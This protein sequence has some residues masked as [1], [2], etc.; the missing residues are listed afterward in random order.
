MK[1]RGFIVVWLTL[2]LAFGCVENPSGI[3][4]TETGNGSSG[5]VAFTGGIPA[6]GAN[7]TLV[8]SS[9]EELELPSGDSM[10]FSTTTD[11]SGHYRFKN[12]LNGY[13]NVFCEKDGYK[14]FIDSIYIA[15]SMTT[16]DTSY[17]KKPGSVSG[18]SCYSSGNIPSKSSIVVC[19]SRFFSRLDTKTGMFK[20]ADLPMGT[21]KVK[22]VSLVPDY[23][24]KEYSLHI[25]EN[26]N[27]SI[28]YPYVLASKSITSLS[29]A[30][31]ITVWV[32]TANGLINISEHPWAIYG[33][34]EGLSNSYINCI[35]QDSS[36]TVWI[37][38]LFRLARIRDGVVRSGADLNVPSKIINIRKMYTTKDGELLIGTGDG[39][40]SY[41]EGCWSTLFFSEAYPGQITGVT[42]QNDLSDISVITGRDTA[43]L[44]GTLH[45]L[46]IRN[47]AGAWSVVK[48]FKN[49]SINAIDFIDSSSY[50]IGTNR[51]LF[52][53]KGNEITQIEFPENIQISKISSLLCHEKKWF[54]GTTNGLFVHEN[55]QWFE[56]ALPLQSTFVTALACGPDNIVWIGTNN[57]LCILE[58]SRVEI[59]Q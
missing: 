18:Y 11:N 48:E 6:S 21:Y 17:L 8:P 5:T 34:R 55:A 35:E 54:I 41:T 45:G 19:G 51:G 13:Y 39:L 7:V 28:L 9:Y 26:S 56:I 25:I 44:I 4:G 29:V 27:D 38:T 36:R 23:F 24:Q 33:L 32:G 47:R 53:L 16:V 30:D 49:T 15:D 46:F 40:F 58:N 22:V 12:L 14:S 3:A 20:L 50:L 2:L 43:L 59:I 42:T 57:G 10:I 31:D 52:T 37:G 1:I